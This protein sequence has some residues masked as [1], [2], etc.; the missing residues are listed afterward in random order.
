METVKAD[1]DAKLG[2]YGYILTISQTKVL[3]LYSNLFIIQTYFK[4]NFHSNV[5]VL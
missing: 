3:I 2:M 1:D 5:I 4:I